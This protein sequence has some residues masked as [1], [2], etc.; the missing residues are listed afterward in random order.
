MKLFLNIIFFISAF[1]NGNSQNMDIIGNTNKEEILDSKHQSWFEDNYKAYKPKPE[2]IE[3]L[4]RLFEKEN[5]QVD[6]YFGTWCSDSQREV[7]RLVKLLEM[8][9]FVFNKFSLIG[10]GRNK[11]VPNVSSEQSKTLN[12]TNVPTII[13]YQNGQE[14]NRF[15]EFA[16]ESLEQDMIKIF[17]NEAYKHSYQN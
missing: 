9:G 4:K 1:S 11:K 17:S 14:I 13:V 10:V 7:P 12:I 5:F 2:S 15:I 3:E 6:V 8:S 16:Q